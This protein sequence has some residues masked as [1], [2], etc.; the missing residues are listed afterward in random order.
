MRIP[1][2]SCQ[3]VNRALND[4]G[5]C[6]FQMFVTKMEDI[7]DEFNGSPRKQTKIETIVEGFKNVFN[8]QASAGLLGRKFVVSR[9]GKPLN[10]TTL[11]ADVLRTFALPKEY[12]DAL[13]GTVNKAPTPTASGAFAGFGNRSAAAPAIGIDNES[14]RIALGAKRLF[15]ELGASL[16]VVYAHDDNDL[17]ILQVSKDA[18]PE[19]MIEAIFEGGEHPDGLDNYRMSFGLLKDIK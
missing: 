9:S 18:K 12:E 7:Q 8:A 13:A 5:A 11:P 1:E 6:T 16:E 4:L 10:I 3:W 17:V 19:S 15:M 14:K 2:T